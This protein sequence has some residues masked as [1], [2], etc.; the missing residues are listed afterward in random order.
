MILKIANAGSLKFYYP[1]TILTT[2]NAAM[3]AQTAPDANEEALIYQSLLGAW[4]IDA[5]RMKQ[6]VTKALRE[7]KT[8]SSW[9]DVNEDYERRVLSFVD[10]LYAN[11]KFLKDFTRF[12]KKIAY[13]GALSSLSQLIAQCSRAWALR[14]WARRSG[15]TRVL[16]FLQKPHRSG[17]IS[18]P[19]TAALSRFPPLQSLAACRLRLAGG[20]SSRSIYA[21]LHKMAHTAYFD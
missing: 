18:L 20:F 4:P 8:H 13:F 12:Q 10:S 3:I 6:Y 9:I 5:G 16:S 7:A 1:K 17:K 14:P 21:R 2:D 15:R 11:D 19:E